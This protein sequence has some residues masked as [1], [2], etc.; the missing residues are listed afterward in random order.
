MIVNF[1]I[2]GAMKSGTTTLSE[3]VRSHPQVEFRSKEMNFFSR[4]KDWR[5]D[6]NGYER[7]FKE[8]PGKIYGE[9][10]THYAYYPEYNLGIWRDIREYNPDMKF[11]YIVRDPFERAVSQY[12]HMYE[13]GYLDYSLDEAL[14]RVP[15]IINNGRYYTQIHPYIETFGADQILILDFEDLMKRRSMV[16]ETV[17]H[18]L[19]ISPAGFS[20]YENVHANVTVGGGKWHYKYDTL[21]A[22]LNV[23]RRFFPRKFRNAVWDVITRRGRRAFKEK[24]VLTK[25]WREVIRIMTRL[26]IIELQKLTGKDYSAWLK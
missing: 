9:A 12:M 2:I 7:G 3:I 23:F 21:K 5:R 11:I 6:I 25:E 14:R 20:S 26:D 13:R 16:L 4:T 18:F 10:S 1:L 22:R 24:P 8:Q 15:S 19:G 17:G